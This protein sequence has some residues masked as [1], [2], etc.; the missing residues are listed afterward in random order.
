M[1]PTTR[2]YWEPIRVAAAPIRALTGS[3][4]SFQNLGERL[5]TSSTLS[6]M[7]TYNQRRKRQSLMLLV[8]LTVCLT[9]CSSLL[10]MSLNS[11]VR[12]RSSESRGYNRKPSQLT[13]QVG[14]G[15]RI[16]IGS[17]IHTLYHCNCIKGEILLYPSIFES[18]PE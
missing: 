17:F 9:D 4:C 8:A 7:Y 12:S 10:V 14:R 15:R 16:A 11:L 6:P 1:V 18:Q 13:H 5:R 2:L 3:A